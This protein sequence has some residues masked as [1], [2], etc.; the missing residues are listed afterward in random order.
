MYGTGLINHPE[1][2]LSEPC[3]VWETPG[4]HV[5]VVTSCLFHLI[6]HVDT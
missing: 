5:E 3:E 4:V 6:Y 2:G 1:D